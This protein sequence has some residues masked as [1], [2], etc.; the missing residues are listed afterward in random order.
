MNNLWDQIKK[1]IESSRFFSRNTMPKI[2][3]IVFAV[4]MW[5]YVMGEINP[6]GMIEIENVPVQLLNVED[7]RESGLVVIGQ[8]NFIV[9]VQV[10][11]RRSDIYKISSQDINARADLRGFRK[12]VNSVPVE[13][14]VPSN[15]EVDIT[16]KQIKITLDEIVKKK[17]PVVVKT[18]GKPLES[19]EPGKASI[20]PNEVLVEG[21]ES[22]INT[23]HS[24]VAQVNIQ[25][26]KDDMVK[27]L[28]PKPI[29]RSGK[30]VGGVEVKN[31][32]VEVNLPILRVKKVPIAISYEGQIQNGVKVKDMK[33][34]Q[35]QVMI[36]G[37]KEVL[38]TITQIQAKPISLK[39]LQKTTKKDIELIFP[40]GIELSQKEKAPYVIIEIENIKSKEFTFAKD[41]I[42]IENIQENYIVDN[43][44]FPSSIKVKVEGAESILE[45]I[46][47]E[48]IKLSI[49]GEGLTEGLYSVKI[50]Y[51]SSQKFEK[52][53]IDP[54]RVDLII[55]G[56]EIVPVQGE[57][58]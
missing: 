33:M 3:S 46:N 24:V 39:D 8:K 45:N 21:P 10:T 47:K 15:I 31:K 20:S 55:K 29:T 41:E 2:I 16:P 35:N 13:V 23:V 5:L 1:N 25:N 36:K 53:T 17:K 19:V 27:R 18:I 50:N 56:K 4:V 30:E 11:G 28:S 34:S 22:L 26:I 48:G 52:I 14:S 7:L 43:S 37:K 57:I 6:Q 58:Q 49:N 42:N 38:D 40:K 51:N 54:E 32:Y 44:K 9:N 12:G